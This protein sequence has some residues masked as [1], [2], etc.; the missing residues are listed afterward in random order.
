MRHTGIAVFGSKTLPTST[1]I[2]FLIDLIFFLCEGVEEVGGSA[3]GW[4]DDGDWGDLE[5]L[6][7]Q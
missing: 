7:I 2:W 4:E 3:D 1:S 5:V 6:V